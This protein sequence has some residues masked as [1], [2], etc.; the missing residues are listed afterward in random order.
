L[1]SLIRSAQAGEQQA[2]DELARRLQPTAV[3][4]ALPLL[5]NR[6]DAQDVAQDA[7]LRLFAN[8]DRFET[9]RSPWPWLRRIVRN[10]A[11]DLLR[12]RRRRETPFSVLVT[13]DDDCGLDPVDRAV[14]PGED[15]I[16][17]RRLQRLVR[18]AVRDLPTHQ[19]EAIELRE[20]QG[21]AYRA[22]AERL[23]IPIG[24]VMSRLFAARRR[25]ADRVT[26][27]RQ[28]ARTVRARRLGAVRAISSGRAEDHPAPLVAEAVSA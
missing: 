26:A 23:D 24:T 14:E 2:L 8:L 17:R 5:G 20:F 18:A 19:R 12:V 7:L 10:A 21:L 22:I 13:D 25:L 9:G 16:D 11:V 27:R 6:E 3:R 15:R 4:W 28:A 1:D